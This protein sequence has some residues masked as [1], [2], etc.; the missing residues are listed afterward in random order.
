MTLYNFLL[1]QLFFRWSDKRVVDTSF[2]SAF[3]TSKTK[4]QK[5]KQQAHKLILHIFYLQL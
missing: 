3:Q 2:A 1:E 5:T 4:K